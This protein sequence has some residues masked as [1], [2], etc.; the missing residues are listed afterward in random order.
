MRFRR[1]KVINP[2]RTFRGLMIRCGRS[3][4]ATSTFFSILGALKKTTKLPAQMAFNKFLTKIKPFVSTRPKKVGGKVARMPYRVL[5]GT[6][7]LIGLQWFNTAARK[8]VEN[9][10]YTRFKLE[11]LDSVNGR[12]ATLRKKEDAHS[13]VQH[14]RFQ[15]KVPKKQFRLGMVKRGP[16]RFKRVGARKITKF[17]V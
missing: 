3:V 16:V 13:E 11:A 1:A 10:I 8:R 4:A 14:N 12:G 2:F 7:D 5:A 6:E 17:R 9:G 15:I